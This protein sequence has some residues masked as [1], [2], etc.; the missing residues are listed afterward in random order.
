MTS[1]R[2]TEWSMGEGVSYNLGFTDWRHCV[3]QNS[4][5]R[6][7]DDTNE[8]EIDSIPIY[9]WMKKGHK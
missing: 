3:S 7:A 2:F 1:L 9:F 5:P 8:D 6:N 4:K